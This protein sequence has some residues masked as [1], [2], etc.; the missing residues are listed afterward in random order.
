MLKKND[1]IPLSIQSVSSQGSGVGRYQGMAVFVPGAAPGDLLQV[2]VVKV[3]SSYCYGIIR[4]V[5]QPGPGRVQ[6]AC[7]VCRRCGGCRIWGSLSGS[8]CQG[9]A[10]MGLS[11][12]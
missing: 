11:C 4:E 5:E 8:K 9:S 3:L 10:H 2:Q 1:L 12:G 6:P 7:P